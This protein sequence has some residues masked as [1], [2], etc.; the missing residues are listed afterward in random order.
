MKNQLLRQTNEQ[1]H[2]IPVDPGDPEVVLEVWVRDISFFDIQRAAQ[3]M[4][5]IKDGVMSLDL[6]SYWKHAFSHWIVRTNPELTVNELLNLKGEIG[7]RIAAVLPSPEKVGQ[8]LQGDFTKG[9]A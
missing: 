2:E 7:Q 9:D 8:M 5:D 4:L 1:K 6:E 3:E